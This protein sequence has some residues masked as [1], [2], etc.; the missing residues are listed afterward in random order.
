MMY[1]KTLFLLFFI[2]TNILFAQKSCFQQ[3]VNYKINVALND[4]KHVVSGNIQMEYTN[5]SPDALNEIWMHLWGNAYKNQRT[6]FAKQQLNKS[7]IGFFIAKNEDLGF[8]S[9]LDFQVNNVKAAWNFD[10]KNPDIAFV[11]LAAPLQ[12]GGKITISTPFSLKIPASFSRLGHVGTSYQITQWFPKPAVY[13]TKG[14]HAMP[15]LDQGEFYSEFGNFDVSVTL[16][17]NYVVGATGICQQESEYAFL[18]RRVDETEAQMK[19]G[20][21]KDISF[22]PS[23]TT[24]K[25]LRFLAENVHDF[26]W[27]ADKRF[28][29]LKNE[30]LLASGKKVDCWTMFTNEDAELWKKSTDYVARAVKFYSDNIGEYPYPHATAVQSAL[31][32]GGGMEYPMITVIGRT[33]TAKDLDI[34]ITHEVGHNWFY[35]ILASNERDHGWMDEGMN[36]YYER[37][38]TN[39]FWIKKKKSNSRKLS[40]GDDKITDLVFDWYAVA[41]KDQAPNTPSIDLLP[42]NYGTCM[43]Q[44]SGKSMELLENYVGA[45]EYDRIMKAYFDKWKFKHPYPEDF[46]KHWE[47]M[48]TKNVAWFFDGLID[49]NTQTQFSFLPLKNKNDLNYDLKFNIKSKG[50]DVPIPVSAMKNGEVVLTKYFEKPAGQNNFEIT[51]P[52]GDYDKVVLDEGNRYTQPQRFGTIYEPSGQ[53]PKGANIPRF[54]LLNI[55]PKP[56]KRFNVGVLPALAF[57]YYDKAQLGLV[58]YSSILPTV[59]SREITVAPLY[60]P[61]TKQLNGG[62]NL[63]QSWYPTKGKISKLELS[64]N[65]RRF[66]SDRDLGYDYYDSY[67]RT[68]IAGAMEFRK[69]KLT[70]TKTNS[71]S[72]RYVQINNFYHNNINYKDKIFR[73]TNSAY[74]IAELKFTSKNT[75][76][77]APQEFNA[78]LQAGK[79]FAKVFLNIN[80]KIQF[81][82]KREALYLHG[83]GG[84]FLK[85][86]QPSAYVPFQVNGKTGLGVVQND[87]MYDSYF[88]ARSQRQPRN[89]YPPVGAVQVDS[90]GGWR[91]QQIVMQDASLR[92]LGTA[93]T[94]GSWMLG[95]GVAY[96]LPLPF[97]VGIRP[98]FDAALFPEKDIAGKTKIKRIW[99]AGIATV[100][101]PD[102]FEVYF[103]IPIK[104]STGWG[105]LDDKEGNLD[106]GKRSKYYQRISF[107]LNINK[108]NPFKLIDKV[109]TMF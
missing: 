72:A 25:T 105:T 86:K 92:T 43:Y 70:A 47:T 21:D 14:W 94:S 46:R 88:L 96:N 33:S 41:N 52:K 102:I 6:G 20:F 9:D 63:R 77:L 37:R 67:V 64:G 90:F 10:P 99:T 79:G 107:M 50:L 16:P 29:V 68:Q 4:E 32:A 23:S 106:F 57:N 18:K 71:I 109:E 17:D 84:F 73:D 83:F 13:D 78:T 56:E 2:C 100:I 53:L 59:A 48:T 8:Y 19:K 1:R 36:T 74:G 34:V 51:F 58:F 62:A 93:S 38:Y 11:K 55:Y 66:S 35:G 80:R 65:L 85:N 45:A 81:E 91:S 95:G 82:R 24:T 49:S 61:T 28:W 44:K 98:Y 40:L 27:F 76:V 108:L 104:R 89:Y 15:Y 75:Y 42:L 26:A 12:P 54:T 30:A 87:Y 3:Q 103:P 5:N 97:R 60:S 101:V 31:S 22:P 69:P 39:A 7:K